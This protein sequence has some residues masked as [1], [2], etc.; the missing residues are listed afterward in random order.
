MFQALHPPRK[1]SFY[2]T[3]VRAFQDWDSKES[4][5]LFVK[6]TPAYLIGKKKLVA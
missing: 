2:D 4:V 6:K 1:A 5:E 3:Y